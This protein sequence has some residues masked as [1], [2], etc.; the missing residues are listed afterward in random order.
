MPFDPRR[1]PQLALERESLAGTLLGGWQVNGIFQV[2]SGSRFTVEADDEEINSQGVTQTADLVGPVVKLG[3][4]GDPPRPGPDDVFGTEDDVAGCLVCDNP[5]PYFDPYAWQQPTGQRLGTSVLTQF[6]GP[7]ATN[8]D[9]SV[10]RAIPL[11]GNR[12]LEIRFEANNFLNKPKWSNPNTGVDYD[13]FII[14]PDGSRTLNDQNFMVVDGT[15]GSMR[16]AR[17]A[18]RFSY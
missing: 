13:T 6:T 15:T 17:V 11:G 12:R 18:L 5:G 7:G 4:I 2:Y 9:F 3:H 14:N 1:H 10:F 8:L 16:Q